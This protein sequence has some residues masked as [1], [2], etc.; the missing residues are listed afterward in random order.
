MKIFNAAAFFFIGIVT[1]TVENA[2][3]QEKPVNN[4]SFSQLVLDNL[5]FQFPQL[6]EVPVEKLQLDSLVQ[7]PN[8][9]FSSGTVKFGTG[10]NQA[11]LIEGDSKVYL[12][13]SPP[14]NL[15]PSQELSAAKL[16][17]LA[18][19]VRKVSESKA[20]LEKAIV[21]APVRGN[22]EAPIT[23]VEFS[24]YQCPYCAKMATELTGLQ[25]SDEKNTRLIVLQYPLEEIHAWARLAA[26]AAECASQQ[27]TDG[28]WV[29][30]DRFYSE[31]KTITDK[32]L[33]EKG[34]E[35]LADTSVDITQWKNCLMNAASP[36]HKKAQEKIN[37]SLQV[38][39]EMNVEYT[40]T[41]FIN[42]KK[43]NGP[44]D[45]TE[46]RKRISSV[47]DESQRSDLTDTVER[48]IDKNL[49]FE[50]K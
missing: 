30:N 46:I 7:I 26:V 21:D 36:A 33:L 39:K 28:F 1:L 34:T 18:D 13:A 22:V 45:M 50:T 17:R 29:L 10:V 6:N 9:G 47:L 2:G 40:P 44:T 41:L 31:Q 14:I 42:G 38:A 3:A 4:K 32:N 16:K 5:K 15:L 11:I 25:K 27:N 19:E 49:A 43:Y 23:I 24:D 20:L 12:L 8:T 48:G 37:Q 35:Y